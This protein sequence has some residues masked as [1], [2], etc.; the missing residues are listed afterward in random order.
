MVTLEVRRV[1]VGNITA[2]VQNRVLTVTG[3]NAANDVEIAGNLSNR[4][5]V[6]GF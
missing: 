1:P 4:V 5:T 3:D 2:A 6:A